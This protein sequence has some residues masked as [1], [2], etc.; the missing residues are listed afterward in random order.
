MVK[1]SSDQENSKDENNQTEEL[2]VNGIAVYFSRYGD[3]ESC[4]LAQC[5]KSVSDEDLIW[6]ESIINQ[7]A[8]EQKEKF[9]ELNR[10][11]ECY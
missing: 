2:E 5:G 8:E 1:R 10:I 6:L 7:R 3:I 4:D 9:R 11:L